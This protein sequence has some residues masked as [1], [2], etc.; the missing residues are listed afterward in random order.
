MTDILIDALNDAAHATLTTL[1]GWAGSVSETTWIVAGGATLA[2]VMRGT[3]FETQA[4]ISYTTRRRIAEARADREWNRLGSLSDTEFEELMTWRSEW[5]QAEFGK[6]DVCTQAAKSSSLLLDILGRKGSLRRQAQKHREKMHTINAESERL[7]DLKGQIDRERAKQSMRVGANGVRRLMMSLMSASED[8]AATA[9]ME[10]NRIAGQIDWEPFLPKGAAAAVR[11]R[12]LNIL[13]R[14]AGTNS[15]GEA[16][17]AYT[18]YQ[19]MAEGH[20][21]HA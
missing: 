17:N 11:T 8:I 7:Q 9:L 21:L 15:L 6:A 5:A 16:R 2:Y 3:L 1:G 12:V 18:Q 19:Q 20:G 14:L 10:L 4:V 13:R